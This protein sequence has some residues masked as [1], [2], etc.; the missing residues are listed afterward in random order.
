[1]HSQPAIFLWQV[2]LQ[3]TLYL[4]SL[5]QQHI[6]APIIKAIKIRIKIATPMAIPTHRL[7]S[8][9]LFDSAL[10]SA[11]NRKDVRL[12]EIF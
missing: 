4:C 11:E 9:L 3:I 1:M 8:H 5:Q 10:H 12:N 2:D 6:I 7:S